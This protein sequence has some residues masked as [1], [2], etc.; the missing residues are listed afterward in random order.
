MKIV[1]VSPGG[2]GAVKPKRPG[3]PTSV[4]IK[5]MS[6]S[7]PTSR[8]FKFDDIPFYDEEDE[9]SSELVV[10]LENGVTMVKSGTVDKL[11]TRLTYEKHPGM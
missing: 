4:N 10:A 3:R 8:A 5:R 7:R 9:E 11:I 6:M 1:T 2:I